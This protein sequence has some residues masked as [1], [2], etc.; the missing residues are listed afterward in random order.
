MIDLEG[1]YPTRQELEKIRHPNVGGVILFARNFQ[2]AAQVADLVSQIRGARDAPLL[3]AVD[4]EGGRVQRFQT[5]FT[6]LPAAASYPDDLTLLSDAGWLLAAELR[7]VD[8]DFSFA[9]VLDVD[10]GISAIIGD[11]AFGNDAERCSQRAL[12]FYRGLR[13]AGMAGV[14]KHF[15][16][17]GGVAA[18]SHLTLPVDHRA[19]DALSERD[20][21]PFQQL[22]GSG[23]EGIMPAHV[24]YACVD[25][26]PAGFSSIWLSQVLRQQ[27]N[28]TGAIFSDDLSMAGA[29]IGGDYLSRAQT[30][31]MAGCDMVLVLNAPD[32]AWQVLEGLPVQQDAQR[33]RRLAALQA[34]RVFSWAS[35]A[36]NPRWQTTRQQLMQL[37]L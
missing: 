4:Q 29:A 23:L 15:P 19:L 2:N 30:A 8:V 32:A 34:T 9:P 12:A 1:L 17:H 25:E 13:E 28:F 10:C 33:Q 37:T 24:V 3:I 11:R 14:G 5:G 26:Q 16:G 18:D 35:L 31:L 27:L 36:D 20:F 22:I 7:C 21:V 6:R